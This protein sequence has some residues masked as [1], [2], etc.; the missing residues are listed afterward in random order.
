MRLWDVQSGTR[1]GPPLMGHTM[2]VGDVEFSPDGTT[3]AS[4]SAD[5]TIR[6]WQV[7]TPSPEKL[8]AKLTY[9]MS[10]GDWE[11]W[12][13]PDIPYQKLCKDLPIAGEG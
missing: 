3:L 8:C 11:M 7:P 6:L 5:K 12:V 2:A 13:G 1:I 9:N 10:P 4:A